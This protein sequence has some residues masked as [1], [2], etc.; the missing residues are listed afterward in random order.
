M[1]FSILLDK[2]RAELKYILFISYIPTLQPSNRDTPSSPN[3]L[4]VEH[5][6]LDILI[7]T[8]DSLLSAV[9]H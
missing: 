5:I 7:V 8:M 6:P 3:Q 2:L 4:I 9:N 1:L